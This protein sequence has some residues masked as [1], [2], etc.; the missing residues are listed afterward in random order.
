MAN[1]HVELLA[2]ESAGI[3]EYWTVDVP[4][5]G[6]RVSRLNTRGKYEGTVVSE[7]TVAVQAFPD[8][9]SGCRPVLTTPK[10]AVIWPI[11]ISLA[12]SENRSLCNNPPLKTACDDPF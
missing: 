5:A 9:W 10:Q 8:M 12:P 1:A 11:G 4:D 7:G 2:Y 3:P 6:V